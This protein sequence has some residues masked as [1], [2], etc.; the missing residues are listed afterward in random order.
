MFSMMA[1]SRTYMCIKV[2]VVQNLGAKKTVRS[3]EKRHSFKPPH[4]VS[5]NATT[6]NRIGW[7]DPPAVERGRSLT[8]NRH[9]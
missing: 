3:N 2:K 1:I 5:E 4:T 7:L 9:V 8:Q 6:L